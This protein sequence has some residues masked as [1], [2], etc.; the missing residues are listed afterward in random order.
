VLDRTDDGVVILPS[1]RRLAP[2]VR[3]SMM[4][5]ERQSWPKAK[6]E[7]D[8]FGIREALKAAQ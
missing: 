1:A 7:N 5:W 2:A 4:S 3:V 8:S 6:K